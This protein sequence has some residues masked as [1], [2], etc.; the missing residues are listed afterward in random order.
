[1]LILFN[2]ISLS[3]RQTL[4]AYKYLLALKMISKAILYIRPNVLSGNCNKKHFHL[5]GGKIPKSPLEKKE[6]IYKGTKNKCEI[7]NRFING[8]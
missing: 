1:M 6:V 4:C 8:H 3:V 5:L 2:S 7:N